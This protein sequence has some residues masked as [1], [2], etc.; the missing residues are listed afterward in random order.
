MK[1]I[2]GCGAKGAFAFKL[3]SSFVAA[4]LSRTLSC[5][6]KS[7]QTVHFFSHNAS[8][9]RAHAYQRFFST[10]ACTLTHVFFI[11][12]I[13][14]ENV[15]VGSDRLLSLLLPLSIPF[16]FPLG[17]VPLSGWMGNS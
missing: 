15:R 7:V 2:F 1:E 13:I 14:R 6:K 17:S 8:R 10:L 3:H 5:A 16:E 12:L 4:K 9:V 11:L